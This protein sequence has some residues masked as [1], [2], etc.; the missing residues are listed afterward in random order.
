MA[1]VPGSLQIDIF[2]T[3]V[4]KDTKPMPPAGTDSDQRKSGSRPGPG[5]QRHSWAPGK[6]PATL[7]AP[8]MSLP[9]TSMED[10]SLTVEPATPGRLSL[11]QEKS[12]RRVSQVSVSDDYNAL[13][14][15]SPYVGLQTGRY[16]DGGL[17]GDSYEYELGA[18]RGGHYPEDSTYDVLDYTHF[19][20][21]LDAEDAPA[22]DMLS[23]RLRQEGAVRRRKT[24][25]LAMGY[26]SQN[27]SWVDLGQ[28]VASPSPTFDTK[29]MEF[30]SP[31]A[32]SSLHGHGGGKEED[33]SQLLN[34]EPG[35]TPL[36]RKQARRVSNPVYLQAE[37][38]QRDPNKPRDKRADRASMSSMRDSVVDLSTVESLMP[39]IGKG[40]R[41]EEMEIQFNDEELED[42]LAMAE[43][44]W[45]GRPM[46]DKL[47]REEVEQ[48]KGATVVACES[49]PPCFLRRFDLGSSLI[50]FS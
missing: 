46:L 47:L 16:G 1:L 48:S 31:S 12:R 14:M 10:V 44:A 25:K 34:L 30:E 9:A 8:R 40:A 23:S 13:I 36:S 15:P 43:Y 19:N 11:P 22:E 49:S 38:G 21:D 24:R 20:G 26:H 45:P 2:V 37:F 6:H 4:P 41:G 18:G 35:E 42:V 29:A 3:N 7:Q 39:K 27:A 17:K 50:L 33:Y 28:Q 32:L 5:P